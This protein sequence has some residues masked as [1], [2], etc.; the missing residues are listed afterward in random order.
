MSAP[1]RSI[2]HDS[3]SKHVKVFKSNDGVA[4]IQ[5]DRLSKRNAFSQSMIDAVVLALGQLDKSSD[6][7]AVVVAG[8]PDGPFCGELSNPREYAGPAAAHIG[9]MHDATTHDVIH[10]ALCFW[11]HVMLTTW[12]A[13]MDLKE[14]VQ[15]S[16][17]EAHQRNFLKDLTDAFARFS[18]P[19][20]AAVVGFAVCP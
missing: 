16:T 19:T 4:V 7:R 3:S 14:L 6:V 5:F 15:I 17:S 20:I 18:K 13:G 9:V 11:K 12:L 8:G 1:I 10:D 2:G